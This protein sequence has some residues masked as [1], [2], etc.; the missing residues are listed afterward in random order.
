MNFVSTHLRFKPPLVIK[1]GAV[2]LKDFKLAVDTDELYGPY[3]DDTFEGD[4]E[5]ADFSQ[6]EINR[7]LL[8][9]FEELFAASGYP[10]PANLWNFPPK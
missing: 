2:G 5:L 6:G 8:Q 1:A 7:L 3:F 9:F 10:R 4:Y